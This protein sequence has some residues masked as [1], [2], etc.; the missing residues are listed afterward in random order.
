V[1]WARKETGDINAKPGG[2]GIKFI[3]MSKKDNQT[4]KQYMKGLIKS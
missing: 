4:L 2:M 3:E 1:A